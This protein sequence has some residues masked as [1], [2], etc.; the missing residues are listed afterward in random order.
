MKGEPV[1]PGRV[2]GERHVMGVTPVGRRGDR[3]TSRESLSGFVEHLTGG[4]ADDIPPPMAPQ[5]QPTAVAPSPD[6]ADEPQTPYVLI[7]REVMSANIRRLAD[8][9]GEHSIGLRPHA[10]THKSLDVAGLQLSHG[11]IGLTV[12]KVSEAEVF[13]ELCPDLLLA[14]PVVDPGRARRVAA[15]ASR[16]DIK[17]AVDSGFAAQTLSDACRA[18]GVSVG[19][20]VDLDVGPHRTGVATPAEAL[21][22]ARAFDRLPG[23]AFR[24]IFA[25][26]GHIWSPKD[27]QEPELRRV[28]DQLQ[29][30]IDR[31]RDAGLDVGIVSGGSTPT[32]FQSHL[33][34]QCTEIRPGTYPFND[35]N[36]VRGGF[37]ELADC[38]ATVVATVVSD[39]VAGQVVI[40]AG[41]KT[42]TSDRC[43][44]DPE[45]GHGYVVEYPQARVAKLSEE[46]GQV[47]VR[48]CPTR[49]KIGDRLS[50]IPN[51]ICPCVNLQD[52]VWWRVAGGACLP[53]AVHARGRLS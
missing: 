42:L 21:E 8:Y 19:V 48:D 17:V 35:I 32:A 27:R 11:A 12:A 31:C 29:M 53:M 3:G 10:K 20:L 4:E 18:A 6:A 23:L 5:S 28:A 47:D 39:A 25:Y 52:R 49:P 1:A 13:A 50:I 41:S 22:L 16:V 34:P 15:L 45:C 43:V 38:A 36:T 30:L 9:A 40:D 33:V 7:D 24:G 14:Y 26:P 37:C 2:P 46:H 51:H 44:P